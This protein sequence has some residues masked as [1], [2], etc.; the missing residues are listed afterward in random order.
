MSS[1]SAEPRE[2]D[3]FADFCRQVLTV[4]DGSP[5]GLHDFQR[6]MLADL[7]DG[8][9]ETVILIPKKNGKSTLLAAL[10]L[11]HLCT[12]PDAECIIVAASRD[13]A[14]VMLRQAQGFIRR[15]DAL[16]E[17]LKVHKREIEHNA[18][19]GRI[20]IL[21]S[22]ADTAD[23]V[24]PT[25]VLVD[26]LHRH[27]SD[28]L[29]GILR[30]GLGPR[31]GKMVTISTAGDS[32]ETPLGRLRTAA[33]AR[34]GMVHDGAY[35]YAKGPG[36]ALHE[37]ALDPEADVDD[38]ELVKQ[39]NPAPWQTVE[40]LKARHGSDSMRPW[41][42]KR[43]ACGIWVGGEDSAVS[44]KQWHD[45][46]VEGLTI[47]SK[48]D[49]AP[50]EPII[51]LDLA[52]RSDCTAVVAVWQNGE[53]Y[54]MEPLAIIAP[55]EDGTYIT[56]E[57]IWEPLDAA[58][59]RWPTATFVGDPA[60]GAD[61]FLE[62]LDSEH[63]GIRAAIFDQKATPLARMA[64]QFTEELAA[65]RIKHPDNPTFNAHVLAAG[66]RPVGEGWRFVKQKKKRLPIDALIAAGMALSVLLGEDED[67]DDGIYQW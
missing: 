38:L 29:Y 45:A 61:I 34:G 9:R 65:G 59:E 63:P 53:Q 40:S 17:R 22:D 44:D 21:A 39:A 60:L 31:D 23:G 64:A 1:Q 5:L 2:L 48:M 10:A 52:R 26:E 16:K 33:Y 57:E 49:G 30:D 7:F 6:R 56:E 43:F 24:I 4:E 42:W 28:E 35:R 50:V 67:Q 11:Y 66:V 12:T 51:G 32:F 55:P 37:W 41:Q 47:P 13:Q 3:L 27:K 14:A 62:R 19:G 58:A 25:L 8:V 20:R 18:L 54:W 46:A 15:S 36:N